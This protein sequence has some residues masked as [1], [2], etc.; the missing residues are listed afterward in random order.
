MKKSILILILVLISVAFVHAD[1]YIKTRIHSDAVTLMGHSQPAVD[2]IREKWIGED[3]CVEITK[4]TTII[5][6]IAKKKV[7]I[8]LHKSKIYAELDIPL[9]TSPL[10]PARLKTILDSTR[11]SIKVTPTGQTQKIGHFNCSGFVMETSSR[12]KVP[13]TTKST[14]WA[15]TY[16]PF[17]WK[18][19]K[20]KLHPLIFKAKKLTMKI[21]DGYLSEI[22]K[23][24]GLSISGATEVTVMGR[25]MNTNLTVLEVSRK[26]SPVDIYAVPAD[27]TK[28]ETLSISEIQ[29]MNK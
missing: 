3:K 28:V 24:E 9:D 13:V 18:T 6:D 20:E 23:V 14:L 21:D 5:A 1:V 10:L 26:D 7:F 16:A 2:T 29:N 11:N 22:A 25:K 27:Y 8:I 4:N 17:D 15:T 19:Y 12:G